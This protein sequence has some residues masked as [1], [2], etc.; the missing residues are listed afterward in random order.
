MPIALLL[1]SGWLESARQILVLSAGGRQQERI[2]RCRLHPDH[3]VAIFWRCWR[4]FPTKQL[5]ITCPLIDRDGKTKTRKHDPTT[6]CAPG[7]FL[8]LVVC[9]QEPRTFLS[10]RSVRVA[11][12][13]N[14]LRQ[15]W[16]H[17][18]SRDG[19]AKL[20]GRR[21]DTGVGRGNCFGGRGPNSEY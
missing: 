12:F 10:D 5:H 6:S 20:R 7:S 21:A 2:A 17:A 11:M 9:G 16:P 1:D 14:W 13:G 4:C 19:R 8:F 15:K 18:C 3:Q